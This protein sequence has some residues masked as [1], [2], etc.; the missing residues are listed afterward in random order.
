M[1]RTRVKICGITREQDVREVAANGADAIG[2]VFYEN[3]PRNVAVEQARVLAASTPAFVTTTA[4]FKDADA[5]FVRQVLSVVAI[6]L[7]QFHG[8]ES[9]DFCRQFE[10]PYIKALGM[11]GEVDIESRVKYYED[12]RGILLDAHAPGADGGTGERFDWNAI[13]SGLSDRLIL[14]GGLHPGNVCDAIRT[15]R[16]YAVDVSSGVEAD[17]GIKSAKL[18][19]EFINEVSRADVQ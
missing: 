18:I 12:A 6:D 1:S 19:A 8:S 2:L 10:R 3:S 15:T 4:L 16:P 11:L 9:A 5:D 14:A 13:P 17:K 7:L